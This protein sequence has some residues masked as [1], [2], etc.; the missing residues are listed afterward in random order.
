MRFKALK[1]MLPRFERQHILTGTPAP[2]SIEDLFAQMQIVDG[3]ERL[4]RYITY[5]PQAVHGVRDPSG[6]AGGRTIEEWYPRAGAAL[7]VAARIETW[8]CA[9][10][11]RTT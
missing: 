5:F 10:R 3:G 9:C 4:G 1:Q 11:P 8:R 7:E 2:Q 6:V